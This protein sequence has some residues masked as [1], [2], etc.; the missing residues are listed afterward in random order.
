MDVRQ[1]TLTAATATPPTSVTY[2]KTYT[3]APKGRSIGSAERNFFIL[4]YP[5]RR[6]PT[7][8]PEPQRS[9]R[10]LPSI[11]QPTNQSTEQLPP[12]EQHIDQS[13][14]QSPAIDQIPYRPSEQTAQLTESNLDQLFEEL[15]AQTQLL[16]E[17][18]EQ[19]SINAQASTQ[20]EPLDLSTKHQPIM[21]DTNYSPPRK[22]R[23]IDT[24]EKGEQTTK[25]KSE[26]MKTE[27]STSYSA[28]M[29]ET[30]PQ[31][32]LNQTAP[33][34]RTKTQPMKECSVRLQRLTSH[35]IE[36]HQPKHTVD[37]KP[38]LDQLK[39]SIR[40]RS[41]RYCPC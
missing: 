18:L 22:R 20:V 4:D 30:S 29:S 35:E 34:S 12:I 14:E 1:Q 16:I 6:I 21:A 36:E 37:A 2:T 25:I 15:N 38:N 33:T 27:P 5:P 41:S 10:Q 26:T 39:R 3:L 23:R 31:M 32:E 17:A 19:I 24:S 7:N 9:S 40:N 28:T 11:E 13:S 8:S